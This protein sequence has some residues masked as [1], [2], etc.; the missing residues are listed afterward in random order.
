MSSTLWSGSSNLFTS[1]CNQISGML[2][3]FLCLIWK[4]IPKKIFL[5]PST[6][7]P[8]PHPGHSDQT[9]SNWLS[10][11]ARLA[12]LNGVIFVLA[13][14]WV[15]TA[16]SLF[17]AVVFLL[18]FVRISVWL[19][20]PTEQVPPTCKKL[21][22]TTA[23]SSLSSSHLLSCYSNECSNLYNFQRKKPITPKC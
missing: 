6:I 23:T 21:G 3:Y 17:V 9:R 8:S 22:E 19:F 15:A 7:H 18:P 4:V 16:L 14:S 12:K 13:L 20:E 5:L 11:M 2:Q 10:T 1:S